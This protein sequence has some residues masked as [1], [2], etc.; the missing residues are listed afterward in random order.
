M[1]PKKDNF[2]TY[3]SKQT[4]TVTLFIR[5]IN[6][7]QLKCLKIEI[8]MSKLWHVYTMDCSII[9]KMTSLWIVLTQ[10]YVGLKYY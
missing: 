7:K 4:F 2:K 5:R 10:G 6:W 1:T 8:W 3:W 9:I